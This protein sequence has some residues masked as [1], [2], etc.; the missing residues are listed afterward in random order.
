[1]INYLTRALFQFFASLLVAF[2]FVTNLSYGQIPAY[3]SSIDFRLTGIPLKE[4][5]SNLITTTHTS[6]TSY[7]EIWS[8]LKVS[9]LDPTNSS[10]VL[11]VYGY[12]DE[13]GSLVNDRTRNKNSNGGDVG[14]WN[15]EHIFPKSLGSPDLG[16]VGP[17]SDPH[18]LRAADVQTN[19][20]RSNRKYANGSGNAGSVGA[21]WFPGEEWKGDV[22]RVIM[23]MYLRYGSRCVPSAVAVGSF[24]AIDPF[25][26]NL[27]LE[28]NAEDAV[29]QHEIDRN[30]AIQSFTG[31]RNPFIDNPAIANLIW[32]G[33]EAIDTWG[34][35]GTDENKMSTIIA[36][37]NPSTG[38]F[39]IAT[40]TPLTAISVFD[41]NGREIYTLN[42]TF[43]EGE[44]TLNLNEFAGGT[45]LLNVRTEKGSEYQKIQLQK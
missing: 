27:L 12:N 21:N 6:T 18:N 25:M 36:Y 19:A 41:L 20:S 40:P 17:G 35:L 26:V 44:Y 3:Y 8:V 2:I 11:L 30:N 5:L 31:N 1:M 22:A 13:D 7:S 33:P 34:N 42:N 16:T 15:R 10:V 39:T 37:P 29:S 32:G 43:I 23:Y 14:E 4:D 38:Y 24:N 45:Y 9:D 28:W